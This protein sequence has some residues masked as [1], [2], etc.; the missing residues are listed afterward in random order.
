M[1]RYN[2]YK[3][4]NLV[5]GR[6][7]WGVHKSTDENDGYLG[8]G[9]ILRQA[10]KKYGKDSFRRKTMVVYETAA[11]AFFDERLLVTQKYLAENPACYNIISGG[12]GG[13]SFTN[14]P[15]KE[16]IRKKISV[17]HNG[18]RH[19]EETKQKMRKLKSEKTKQKMS[20]A[21]RGKNHPMY[22]KHHSE[23]TKQKLRKPRSEETKQKI[24]IAAS[25][26]RNKGQ[27]NAMSRTNREKR[28]LAACREN[29]S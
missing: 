1:K 15:N 6:F 17:S 25:D 29:I 11:D 5:N 28:R 20:V 19:T 26:G 3:T 22:D 16:E 27:N 7:Y 2:I 4:T 23:E 18:K 12:K 9:K 14:N 21:K 13:D 8:S 10:I 24:S